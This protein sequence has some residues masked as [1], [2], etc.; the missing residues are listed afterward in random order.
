MILLAT[1]AFLAGIVTILSPCILP[2]LPIVLSTT[3]SGGKARPFGIVIGFITSFTFFTLFLS[4][5]VKIAGVSA[6]GLRAVAVVL[7]ALFGVSLIVPRMQEVFERLFG[8]LSGLAPAVSGG[9]FL[10]GILMGACLGLLWAPCVGPI[11]ASVITLAATGTVTTQTIFITAAYATGTAIPMFVIMYGG[12]NLLTR[13]PWLTKNT[14]GIQKV[15]GILMIATALAILLNLDRKFQAFI[16]QAF[17]QYGTNLTQFEDVPFV[18]EKLKSLEQKPSS[19]MLKGVEFAPDFAGGT[20]WF[21]SEPLTI[22]ELRGKVVVVDFWTYTCINCIRTL[23]YLKE[24]H[25]KY[26]DKGLTIIGVHTPEFEFEKDPKNVEQA[27]KDFGIEYPVVQDNEYLI[28]KA[29]ENHYWPAKYFVDK[30]GRIRN[31]HFGEGAYKE[32]EKLIQKLLTEA[33]SQAKEALISASPPSSGARTPETYLGYR[34]MANF[35]SPEGVRQD[36]IATYTIPTGLP[37]RTFAY[38]GK[39][40]IGPEFAVAKERATLS[41]RFEAKEVY[42]VMRPQ[43]DTGRVRIL[44]DDNLVESKH[45]GEDVQDSFVTVRKD[46]MYRLI[47]L[48]RTGLHTLTLELDEGIEVYAFTFG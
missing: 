41:F 15:F 25:R 35:A 46:R 37:V 31:S 34:R 38:G 26:R 27:I 13:V 29:Y 18:R 22:V 30:D 2:L 11:L 14:V 21:N 42:L 28:W 44:L 24:W 9:G 1:F 17:P 19:D 39:W 7:I 43:A 5:L 40:H 20:K 16:V 47:R 8:K 12:R 32:S 33:G 4:Y 10:S 48:P 6:D 3:G 23:P 45:A 36:R